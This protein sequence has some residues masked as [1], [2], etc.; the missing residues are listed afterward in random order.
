MSGLL[1]RFSIQVELIVALALVLR[2]PVGL[3]LFLIERLQGM[4]R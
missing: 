4:K 3:G 1:S 2:G